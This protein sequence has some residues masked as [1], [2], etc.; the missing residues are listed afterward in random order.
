[1]ENSITENFYVI[2][3]GKTNM[4]WD[5]VNKSDECYILEPHPVES[6]HKCKCAS[7]INNPFDCWKTRHLQEAERVKEWIEKETKLTLTIKKI[8]VGID[9]AQDA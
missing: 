8:T 1:M 3:T 7:V 6:D 5:G 2:S 9:F 4:L